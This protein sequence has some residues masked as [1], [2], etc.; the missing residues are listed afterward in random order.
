MSEHKKFNLCNKIYCLKS[1]ILIIFKCYKINNVK[2][3]I[4]SNKLYFILR[5]IFI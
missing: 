4:K 2:K 1:M 3:K 5:I